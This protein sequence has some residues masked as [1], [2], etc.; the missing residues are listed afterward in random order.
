LI[1]NFHSNL[2]TG[3]DSGNRLGNTYDASIYGT[4][5]VG[6]AI[7][8]G[9]DLVGA[10][11]KQGFGGPGRDGQTGYAY[12]SPTGSTNANI[13]GGAATA[14]TRVFELD[15]AVA[16][17]DAKMIK[18][19]PDLLSS[20]DTSIGVVVVDIAK[21][22][23]TSA[24]GDPDFDNLSAFLLSVSA[25]GMV[26]G[27]GGVTNLNQIRRLTDKVSAADSQLSVESIRFVLV[28]GSGETTPNASA[29]LASP[30]AAGQLEMPV[31]DQIDAS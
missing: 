21:S 6:A 14:M 17:S 30:L 18:Y 5:Q 1:S 9:V 8:D 24:E 27:L 26:T 23:I 4:D 15:G 2:G 11:Y 29:N 7:I 13:E 25:S 12:A 16:E 10:T 22:S 20:T 3:T 28:N 19:D 31:K